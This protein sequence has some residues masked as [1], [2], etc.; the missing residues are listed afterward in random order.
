MNRRLLLRGAMAGVVAAS[1]GR[2]A[3]AAKAAPPISLSPPAA[4][5]KLNDK[6]SLITGVGGNV[7]ALNTGE[8]LLLADGGAS[9]HTEALQAQLRAL[10]GDGRVQTLFNT[11][12]HLEQTGSNE[13]FGRAGAKIIAHE[14]TK[15]WLGTDHYVPAED[16]YDKARLKEALPTQ[17][18]YASGEMTAG[19]EHIEYGYLLEA[20]TDGDIYVFFRDSNVIAAGGTVAS[21][22]DPELDWY[23]GGWLG[24]RVDALAL[25]LKLGNADTRFVAAS[26]PVLTR[27]QVE[28][29]YDTL[30]LVFNRMV[31]MIRKGF[32]TQD[33]FGAGV[34]EGSARSWSDPQKFLH[35]AHKSI[36][37]HH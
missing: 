18:F 4:T 25:L 34:L 8:G 17:T 26:G 36:W 16:R 23:A 19:T 1:F 20:H 22:D 2:F 11:H 35:D 14:N 6:L 9:Q 3:L 32:T 29:E 10:S 15:L 31:D 12:W 21:A 30:L 33:M 37:A 27:A 5:T 13:A 7:V 28:A 24:G